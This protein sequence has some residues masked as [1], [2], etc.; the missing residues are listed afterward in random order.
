MALQGANFWDLTIKLEL[1]SR[2]VREME[3]ETPP[4]PCP[5]YPCPSCPCPP[6]PGVSAP[7]HEK[8]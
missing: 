2:K 7:V 8:R 6:C 3:L 4:C 5:P 1:N